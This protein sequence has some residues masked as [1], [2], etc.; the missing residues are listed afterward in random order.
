MKFVWEGLALCGKDVVVGGEEG[1]AIAYGTDEEKQARWDRFQ[2]TVNGVR[3][4][5][6]E[7]SS[8][9]MYEIAAQRLKKMGEK[10]CSAG[11]LK[12]HCPDP[13]CPHPRKN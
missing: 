1:H 13:G 9:K 4:E 2:T 11:T 10:F 7:I 5:A 8:K 3:R 12:R 6:P